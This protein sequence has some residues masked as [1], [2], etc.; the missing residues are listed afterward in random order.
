MTIHS[1]TPAAVNIDGECEYVTDRTFEIVEKGMRFV[2]PTTSSYIK[3]RESGKIS[4]KQ[5][6]KQGA[7]LRSPFLPGEIEK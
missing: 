4:Q 1:D 5:W 2:I 6:A 7:V 3:D